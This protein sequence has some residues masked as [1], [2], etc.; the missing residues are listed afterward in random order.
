ML[1]M[2]IK[3]SF[4]RNNGFTIVE[5]LIV[6]VVIAILAAISIVAY[7]GIQNR[8]EASKTV[9]AIQAY[10]KALSL[11]KIDNNLYPTTGAMC[12]GE[13]YPPFSG[14][15]VP[16]CRNSGSII[17]VAGN[18][19]ARDLLKPYLGGQLPM[20]SIKTITS[21]SSDFVGGHF[22]G[23]GY[24]YTLDGNP[25]V[26]IEYYIRGNTCPVGPVYSATPPSFTSPSVARSATLNTEDSRCFLLLPQ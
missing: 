15:T 1:S 10:K 21:G 23:S 2:S 4:A 9:S 20:P 17:G 18:A 6:I 22:Y 7:N 16:A 3:L 8:A 14:Q 11:Y 13:E 12:L 25:V 19:A 24:N 5:L 26:T